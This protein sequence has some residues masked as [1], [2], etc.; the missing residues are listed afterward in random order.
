MSRVILCLEVR[1]LYIHI[2]I[3]F[4]V[5]SSEFWVTQICGIK[6]Y[7]LIQIICIHSSG[8][9]V[10]WDWRIHRLL[11]CTGVRPRQRVSWIWFW[12]IW[13]CDSSNAGALGNAEYPF[14]AITPRSTIALMGQLELNC[15]LMLNWIVRNRIEIYWS[16][17]LVG[18]VFTKGSGDRGSIPGRVIL[19]TLKNGTW[20]LL[21]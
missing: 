10:G 5:I 14:I 15:A 16:I 4:Y 20:C 17:S 3:V 6:K 21:A 19:K 2:N 7:D 11:L 9:P 8:C 12:I 1:K 13:W 18:W